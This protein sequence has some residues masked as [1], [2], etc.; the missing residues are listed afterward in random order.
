[1]TIKIN[2]FKFQI[3]NILIIYKIL[4]NMIKNKLIKI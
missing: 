2:K 1:M 3:F 4:I